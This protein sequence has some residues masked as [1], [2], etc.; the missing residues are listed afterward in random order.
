M[1]LFLMI[2][3]VLLMAAGLL[4]WRWRKK[5]AAEIEEGAGVEWTFLRELEP[6]FVS[7]L[8]ER[9]FRE[10]YARAHQPRLPGYALACLATF[11][12]VLPL[13]LAAL[14]LIL[15]G[16]EQVGIVPQPVEV[17]EGLLLEDGE[18]IFFR[19]TPPEAALYYI[20]DLAGFYHFFGVLAVWLFVVWFYMRRY[21]RRRPGYLRDEIIRARERSQEA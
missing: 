3:A 8:S 10:I 13:A 9:D 11:F 2:A 17:A 4:Y 6:E 7:G 18:M 14:T 16:A 15:R 20:R 1:I 12:A 21:H 5:V 19:E